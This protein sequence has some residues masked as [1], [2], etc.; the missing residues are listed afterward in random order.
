[1]VACTQ[2]VRGQPVQLSLYVH[3]Y[4]L[5]FT[6]CKCTQM[7]FMQMYKHIMYKI[8]IACQ[9]T[10]TLDVLTTFL[11]FVYSNSDVVEGHSKVF[12]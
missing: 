6:V 8:I 4:R 2:G 12:K 11:A 9:Y 10:T 1:M 5:R 7:H 3:M